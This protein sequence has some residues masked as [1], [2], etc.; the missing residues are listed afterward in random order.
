MTKFE[1]QKAQAQKERDQACLVESKWVYRGRIV[2]LKLE[3]YRF[4][5]RTKVAEIVHRPNCIAIVP[6][7]PHGRIVLVQQWRRAVGEI[8]VELPAG[9]I[10][11]NEKPIDCANRELREETGFASKEIIP[12]GGFYS[13]PGFCSEYMHLFA[14][15]QLYSSPLPPDQDEAI[16]LL[17]LT[18]D[19]AIQQIKNNQIHDAKTVAGILRYALFIKA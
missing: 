6:I 7:D 4:G 3:T 5:E 2:N 1:A 9:T 16:D 12:L 10:E 15:K 14:A 8:M 11:E 13:T 17:F 18:L 19:E